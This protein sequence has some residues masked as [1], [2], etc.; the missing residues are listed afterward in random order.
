VVAFLSTT[1]ASTVRA[2]EDKPAIDFAHTVVPILKS[3]CVEC[4]GGHRHEG[5]FSINT[6]EMIVD[7]SSAIPGNSA[8]SYIIEMVTAADPK[9]RM[10]KD[11]PPLSD[12]DV[13]TLRDWIDAGLPWEPGFSFAPRDY[14][15]PLRPRRP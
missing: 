4:H 11:K 6:R 7:S 14:E 2:E 12:A 10:P 8:E 15:P 9:V 13:Q 1:G 3:H 5:D